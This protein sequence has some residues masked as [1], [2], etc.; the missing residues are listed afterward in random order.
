MCLYMEY[1]TVDEHKDLMCILDKSGRELKMGKDYYFSDKM[2]REQVYE[3]LYDF[4]ADFWNKL[5]RIGGEE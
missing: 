3:L 4:M 1:I 5:A 2:S